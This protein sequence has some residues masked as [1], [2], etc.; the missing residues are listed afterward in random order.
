[1]A[2]P[3]ANQEVV[4]ISLARM[5]QI[6]EVDPECSTLNAQAGCIVEDVQNAAI[7]HDHVFAPD[8]GARGS[9]M[10]GGAVA[11]NGGG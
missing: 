9:A 4:V 5:R 7:A 8:W 1:M 2:V 6:I 10:V 3:L 11:T